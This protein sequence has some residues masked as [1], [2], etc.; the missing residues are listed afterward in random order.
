LRENAR[1]VIQF[2]QLF[3]DPETKDVVWVQ[4][5]CARGYIVITKDKRM[6][7]HTNALM[8]W[9]RNKGKIFFIASGGADA[10]QVDAA[11]LR[12]LRKMEEL[13]A[14]LAGPFYVRVLLTGDIELVRPE[15]LPKLD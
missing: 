10:N 2:Q 6:L 8:A 4:D 7:E 9:H 12:A 1:K 3:K 15:A 14:K 5:V 13:I 11:V